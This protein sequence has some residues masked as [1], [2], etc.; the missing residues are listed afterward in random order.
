MRQTLQC[1]PP[2]VGERPRILILGTMPGKESLARQQYYANRRNT[3]WRIVCPLLHCSLEAD[4]WTRLQSLRRNAIALWDVVASCERANSSSD[5]KIVARS[6]IANDIGQFLTQH[7]SIV[8]IG[9]NGRKAEEI[10]DKYVKPG[11]TTSRHVQ[12]MRL[13]STSPAYA[14]MTLRRKRAEWARLFSGS[15]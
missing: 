13:P 15:N 5:A 11:L 8:R 9:F 10:F 1:L 3:F 6:I 14:R 12:R 2:V 4:Y 7:S